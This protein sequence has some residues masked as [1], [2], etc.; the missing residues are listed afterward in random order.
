VEDVRIDLE[1]VAHPHRTDEGHRLHCDGD[2]AA[3]G[4]L[5]TGDATGLVHP[6]HDPAAEDVP[7]GVGIGGHRADA[8]G[9]LA[10]RLGI[11]RTDGKWHGRIRMRLFLR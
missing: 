7:V 4:P 11:R 3:L 2:D 10:A 6:R 1:H 8:D 9:E 5:D